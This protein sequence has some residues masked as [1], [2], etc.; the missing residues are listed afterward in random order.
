MVSSEPDTSPLGSRLL[1]WANLGAYILNIVATSVI[2]TSGKVGKT[3]S[4]VSA[5]YPTLF[6]PAGYAFSIWGLIFA[7]EGA[8]ALYQLLPSVR[9]T[10]AIQ[11]G[12]GP[13][14]ILM[15]LL[16]LG[17]SLSFA[18]ESIPLSMFFMVGIF[19][20]LLALTLSLRRAL[21]RRP[22][23]AQSICLLLPFSLN[24]GWIT[25]AL[26]ANANI[27]AVYRDSEDLASHLATAVS[28]CVVL[29]LAALL[30]GFR[31]VDPIFCLVLVWAGT[32]IAKQ[33][34]APVASISASFPPP[35]TQGLSQAV[36]VLVG[37][38]AL[39]ALHA[40]GRRVL[41]RRGE[42]E[43]T[44]GEEKEGESRQGDTG[45]PAGVRAAAQALLKP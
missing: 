24:F 40:A 22:S 44:Q 19:L 28:S 41:L 25:A 14:W 9:S 21:P 27:V 26:L 42:G 8:F 36:F 34:S 7:M 1:P 20:S 4:E 15:V 2:G 6:T 45:S 35:V 39:A 12:V 16:Q 31:L 23:L 10:P 32:A 37:F 3:N 43:D 18:T 30:G 11:K 33:L 13:W 38:A 17:W 5:A 29:G